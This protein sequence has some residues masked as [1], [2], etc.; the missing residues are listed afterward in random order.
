[1]PIPMVNIINGGA[2][3]V[4]NIDI[5]EFMIMPVMKSI[6]ERVRAASEVFHALKNY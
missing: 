1:M 4:N 3:A 2:H 6:K 5:Q